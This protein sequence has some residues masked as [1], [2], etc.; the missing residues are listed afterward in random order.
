VILPVNSVLPESTLAPEDVMEK[1]G[2]QSL[3]GLGCDCSY[4]DLVSGECFD[5]EPCASNTTTLPNPFG[6]PYGTSPS[7]VPPNSST[8]GTRNT[9][10]SDAALAAGISQTA[11]LLQMLAI[12][13]GTTVTNQG[14]S[15]Q[16]A[17]FPI[18]TA[19]LNTSVSA[20]GN[21]LPLLLIG[22]VILLAVKK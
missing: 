2:S 15:R 12:Q 3:A 11:R 17:G 21:M 14:I 9:S 5:P 13:P 6:L 19:G 7:G 18:S 8:A 20:M 22:G 1:F 16:A 4:T 10:S